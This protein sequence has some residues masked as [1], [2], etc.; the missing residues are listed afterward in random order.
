MSPFISMRGSEE[1]P[2]TPQRKSFAQSTVSKLIRFHD[3]SWII[4]AE[5]DDIMLPD[6]YQMKTIISDSKLP[7]IPVY[8]RGEERI[9]NLKLPRNQ[10]GLG[11][12][13]FEPSGSLTDAI[14]L[15]ELSEINTNPTN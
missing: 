13:A 10:T 12:C 1:C 2:S 11:S 3:I 6:A 9:F 8:I 4:F 5:S 15:L 7:S 14:S